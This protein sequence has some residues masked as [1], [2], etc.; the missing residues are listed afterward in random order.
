MNK[1]AVNP[2]KWQDNFSFSQGVAVS[3]AAHTLIC[4]GQASIS[5]DGQPLHK[6][7]MGAQ[8]QLSLQ[9]VEAVLSKAN[10]DWTHV[11]RLT[12]Y[13][14]DFDRLF[15]HYGLLADKLV[16]T[17]PKPVINLLGINRLVFPE[18]LVELE[19]TAMK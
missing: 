14:V 16:N 11:V 19:V 18:L 5:E 2:W 8:L 9:N 4:A 7:D 10:Y 15:Q 17:E 13:T 6:D 1:N 12:V 3:G